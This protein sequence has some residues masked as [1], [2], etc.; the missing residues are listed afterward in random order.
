MWIP[1]SVVVP[2]ILAA[3]LPH[4]ALAHPNAGVQLVQNDARTVEGAVLAVRSDPVNRQFPHTHGDFPTPGDFRVGSLLGTHDN[5]GRR[6]GLLYM[7]VN[8]SPLRFL[9]HFTSQ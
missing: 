7:S 5:Q 4:H 3:S 8:W 9:F 1:L 6:T 2:L